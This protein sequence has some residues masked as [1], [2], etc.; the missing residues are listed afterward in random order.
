MQQTDLVPVAYRDDAARMVQ[1]IAQEDALIAAAHV[2]PDGDAVSSL[3]AAGH[4]LRSLH[5][6]FVLYAT[7]GIPQY[8][9]FLPFPGVVH[10]SLT[11]LP[12][13]PKAA[14]LLDCGEPQRLG[15][16][17]AAMLPNLHSLNIDHHL[18]NGMG[19]TATWVAPQ[20]AATAQLL[21]YV[22]HMAGLPLQG[23]LA[24]A[25]ALGIITDTGGFSHGNTTSDV[26]TLVAHLAA[27]GCNIAHLRHQL[28]DNWSLGRMRLWGQLMGS[29]RLEYNGAIA[30]C[31]VYLE[32]LRTCQAQKEDLEGFVE[33]MRRLRGVRVAAML[34]Q[35]APELCKLSLRSY[36]PTD[37]RAMAA[38]FGGGGH[39]NAAG[40]TVR[41]PMQQAQEAVIAAIVSGLNGNAT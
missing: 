7:P 6:E 18:G 41:L 22:A 4:I 30:L 13:T 14:L 2:A 34:R 26:L 8:L 33:Q 31:P 19:K 12:F 16:D 25:L 32:D 15:D 40:A 1:A 27:N 9:H 11:R 36:G 38:H 35:D 3:A 20:A 17:L 23:E 39:R 37:V 21:A 29:F 10:T 24:D 5:K 28:D